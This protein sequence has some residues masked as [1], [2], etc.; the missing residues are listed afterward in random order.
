MD[1]E[2]LIGMPL[3][4]TDAEPKQPTVTAAQV[5]LVSKLRGVAAFANLMADHVERWPFAD[6]LFDRCNAWA[7]RTMAEA[8]AALVAFRETRDCEGQG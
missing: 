5:A 2:R 7:G 1:L 3:P 8:D 4:D 6:D